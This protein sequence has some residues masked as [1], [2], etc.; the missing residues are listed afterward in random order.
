[1]DK[2]TMTTTSHY[3]GIVIQCRSLKTKDETGGVNI[4]IQNNKVNQSSI[5]R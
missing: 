2:R 1:M 5:I 4:N 3:T